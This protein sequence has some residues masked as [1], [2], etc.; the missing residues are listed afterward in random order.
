MRPPNDKRKI[1]LGLPFGLLQE[2]DSIADNEFRTR[3]DLIREALRR[4]ADDYRR[5]KAELDNVVQ[6]KRASEK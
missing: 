5:H 2:I 6:L 1:V 3:T 4:Y